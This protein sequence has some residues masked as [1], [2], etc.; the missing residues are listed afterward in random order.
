MANYINRRFDG[1]LPIV[2][3]IETSGVDAQKNAIL[4]IA[5]L[6]VDYDEAGLLTIKNNFA[7][8][9]TPSE[10]ARMDDAAMKITGI[11]P[12]HPF[13]FDV[14]ENEALT[15]LFDFA[16]NALQ[17]TQCRRAVLVGHN[18]H[19]DLSFILA[20]A[21]R[22]KMKKTPFHSFTVFDTATLS[23]LVYGKTVLA[24][25]LRLARLGFDKNEAHS[26]IYDA[27]QTAEL[28]CLIVNRFARR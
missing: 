8:H 7:C 27:K 3:D 2:I 28:F 23:G 19:F 15:Q 11:D 21:K 26:A 13:R 22:C 12:Y 20:A 5:A 24:K 10:G 1:Y 14:P 6:T 17:V 18:A 25:A 4:E 9:V 16:E